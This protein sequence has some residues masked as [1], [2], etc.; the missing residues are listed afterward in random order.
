MAGSIIMRAQYSSLV[1]HGS[2]V[3]LFGDALVLL[4]SH[5]RLKEHERGIEVVLSSDRGGQGS[6]Q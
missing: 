5:D 2:V 3:L 4:N 6:L 1:I